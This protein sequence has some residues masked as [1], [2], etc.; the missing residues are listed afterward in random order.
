MAHPLLHTV[1]I[2]L[3]DHA[4]AEGVAKVVE[5]ELADG[6]ALEGGVVAPAKRAAIE[7]APGLADEDEIFIARPAASLAELRK[8]FSD[9]GCP[10]QFRLAPK[11]LFTGLF[12]ADAR[13]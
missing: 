5:A 4:S 2:G 7:V 10:S 3:G 12:R 11:G 1:D 6:C 13:T 8:R 9:V